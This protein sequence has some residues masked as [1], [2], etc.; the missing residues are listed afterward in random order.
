M[1][2]F[3]IIL[4]IFVSLFLLA[5][6]GIIL[7]FAYPKTINQDK[8]NARNAADIWLEYALLHNPLDSYPDPLG[9]YSTALYHAEDALFSGANAHGKWED[10]TPYAASEHNA[11]RELLS[12][13]GAHSVA[14]K[15]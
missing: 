1:K 4:A 9:R 13:Y 8:N 10:G 6:I 3:R 2:S 14:A 12:R 15:E 5:S 11:F 7:F